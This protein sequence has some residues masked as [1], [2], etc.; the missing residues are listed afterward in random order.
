MNDR[1]LGMSEEI[2]IG[3]C[4]T[5]GLAKERNL[6]GITTE[7]CDV[8]LDEFDGCADIGEA[9]VFVPSGVGRESKDVGSAASCQFSING[10][11]LCCLLAV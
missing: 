11:C 7:C 3:G 10:L 8:F 9:D 5:G 4:P 6:L 2:G 1:I